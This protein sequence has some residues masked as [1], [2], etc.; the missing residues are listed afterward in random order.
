MRLLAAATA[1]SQLISSADAV[2]REQAAADLHTYGGLLADRYAWGALQPTVD[3]GSLID[4]AVAG[5]PG[6]DVSVEALQ[7]ALR[8]VQA[9][10]TDY[11]AW[12]ALPDE[13][14][15]LGTCSCSGVSLAALRGQV[16]TVPP[17]AD[18]YTYLLAVCDEIPRAGLPSGCNQTTASPTAVRFNAHNPADCTVLGSVG[19][20][21]AGQCGMA[22]VKTEDG[23][24]VSYAY[25]DHQCRHSL[26]LDITAGGHEAVPAQVQPGRGCGYRAQW[27]ADGLAALGEESL[28]APFLVYETAAGVFVALRPDRSD[29]VDADHPVLKTIDSVPVAEWVA[30]AK[31]L[32]G[33]QRRAVRMLTDV[34]RLRSL[35]ELQGAVTVPDASKVTLGLA[36]LEGVAAPQPVSLAGVPS[37]PSYGDGLDA[38]PRKELPE[39][40][41]S[42]RTFGA[43]ILPGTNT[44]YIRL[45][46]M[47]QLPDPT[48]GQSSLSLWVRT[49][50]QAMAADNTGHPQ[51][52]FATE[53]LV[54]DV[55]GSFGNGNR[56]IVQALVPFFMTN[57]DRKHCQLIGSASVALKSRQLP[58][59]WDR[60]EYLEAPK[61][62][63]PSF[64]MAAILEF[65]KSFA[66]T[67]VDG[68]NVTDVL[69]EKF[70]TMEYM[71]VP[72]QSFDITPS[73]SVNA[74]YH[75]ANPVIV[76]QDEDSQGAVEVLLGAFKALSKIAPNVKLMGKT[77]GGVVSSMLNTS[78]SSISGDLDDSYT[79][80]NSKI[81]VKLAATVG[82]AP[83]GSPYAGHGIVPNIE[84]DSDPMSLLKGRP[85]SML[86]AAV[87]ELSHMKAGNRGAQSCNRGSPPNAEDQAGQVCLKSYNGAF[88]STLQ[89]VCYRTSCT[90]QCQ[91]R[92]T[93]MLHTCS[94]DTYEEMVQY[95]TA[96]K[97]VRGFNT[98]AVQ[99]LTILGPQNCDYS[100]LATNTRCHPE[101][102]LANVANGTDQRW[103]DL[104]E[105]FHVDM[106]DVPNG[107]GG[108][109]KQPLAVWD[110]ETCATP[111]C[112]DK[113]KAFVSDCR[114]CD[115][116]PAELELS[117]FMDGAVEKL[118]TCRESVGSCDSVIS[119]VTDVCC[120]GVDCAADGFPTI[121]SF[122]GSGRHG[123]ESLCQEAVREAAQTCPITF[124]NV[125]RRQGLY[126]VR[127]LPAELPSHLFG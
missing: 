46:T 100:L 69:H 81:R 65:D 75:Y 43:Q 94:N 86:A 112:E 98:R 60:V 51:G 24:T 18:G 9:H 125:S 2:S 17:G 83:D 13:P 91:T 92:I 48:A 15:D 119:T 111:A 82:F 7:E 85:D 64:A 108:H 99:A 38:W 110:P 41:F 23:L 30:A 37:R 90:S 21:A 47:E 126:M 117:Y 96:T 39:S 67:G 58:P 103:V 79:L 57:V 54:I 127:D 52:V 28:F 32:A 5:L 45:P 33:Q 121:C 93:D 102:S 4:E 40:A 20:C 114:A 87:T 107:K 36:S 22:S 77:S 10:F 50:L 26:E 29:W 63:D 95:Y 105:C 12:V 11:G 3:A 115:T 66:P 55:R 34:W 68:G 16:R 78:T 8:R 14:C 71:A 44:G 59:T 19:A 74:W 88:H 124:L 123:A 73:M 42:N 89:G 31:A 53:S 49:L 116:G 56:D 6:G 80:P 101:C 97:V 104:R 72:S 106:H 70:N 120:S 35:R 25:T 62:S 76:L 113:F 27:A 84:F 61:R 109:S 118:V 122:A 1:V